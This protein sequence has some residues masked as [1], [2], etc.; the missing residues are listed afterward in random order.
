[1]T[2]NPDRQSSES[3]GH[4]VPVRPARWA[5]ESCPHAGSQSLP[6]PSLRIGVACYGLTTC[7]VL[8]GAYLGHG[9]VV[10][11][12][13]EVKPNRF[14]DCLA[15]NWDGR[16]YREIVRDGYSFNPQTNSSAAFFPAYPAL[17]RLVTKTTQI[18]P[19][20][21]LLIVSHSCL[22][23]A[24]V[25][26]A[27][28]VR[29]RFGSA[30][31]DLSA[32]SVLA[33][34][35]FPTTFFFRM[36]YSESL[37]LLCAV[38]AFYLMER[39]APLWLV[40]V[41]IGLTTACRIPGVCLL[42]P[43]AL[44]V[45]RSSDD[46]RA[47]VRKLLVLSPLACWGIAAFMLYTW[48]RFGDPLAFVKAQSTWHARLSPSW[49][50]KLYC[51]AIFEPLRSVFDS[52]S[53]A[54]WKIRTYHQMA[55]FSLPAFNPLYF[56]LGLV[57]VAVGACRR[58]L[59]PMEW[60]FAGA[61]LFIG[62]VGRGYEMC[63]LSSGRFVAV[64]FPIYLVLGQLLVRCPPPLA[65]AFLALSSVFLTIYSALFAAGQFLI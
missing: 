54:Y 39:R 23:G 11:P 59:S 40:A 8:V 21:A 58:W 55:V 57:L 36:G 63:M 37:F 17:T 45:W 44:H 13:G 43:F 26:L 12:P 10:S 7:L 34:G 47:G 61:L 5:G 19:E 30:S 15:I 22:A 4:D 62:Y 60:S 25:L 53:V 49:S 29:L 38:L 27:A 64:V 50:H 2:P 56:V 41:V 18:S 48:H 65:C 52:S 16:W 24:L 1:M 28:Y 42:C 20:I 9:L 46:K 31:G 3:D 33:A 32:F 51:L 14:C 6:L 35:V